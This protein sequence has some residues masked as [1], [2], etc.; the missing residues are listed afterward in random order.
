MGFESKAVR[1]QGGKPSE[2]R[3]RGDKSGRME[4]FTSG[5]GRPVP[6]SSGSAS[7]PVNPAKVGAD[8]D[9]CEVSAEKLDEVRARLQQWERLPDAAREQEEALQEACLRFLAGPFPQFRVIYEADP[10]ARCR[11]RVIEVAVPAAE[12]GEWEPVSIASVASGLKR[13]GIGIAVDQVKQSV[14]PIFVPTS[15]DVAAGVADTLLRPEKLVAKVIGFAARVVAE[16]VAQAAG[17]P[18]PFAHL[19]G[20]VVERLCSS[21]QGRADWR[22]AVARTVGRFTVVCD[23][24]GGHV[25]P[26]VVDYA[27]DRLTGGG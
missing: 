11:V 15:L 27:L 7:E 4:R 8:E 24:A 20:S 2:E 19:V 16:A 14:N 3:E 22:D 26:R 18:P 12:P 5:A 17:V 10:A 23:L 25:T 21:L 6:F 1:G 13:V 9:A